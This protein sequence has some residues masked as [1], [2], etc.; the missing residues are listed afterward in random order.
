MLTMR[1]KSRTRGMLYVI[2]L[3]LVSAGLVHLGSTLA[4]PMMAA[5]SGYEPLY[6]ALPVN[7]MTVLPPSTPGNEPLTFHD[8]DQ[9]LAICRY[10]LGAGSLSVDV[11]LPERGW[12][13]GLYTPTGENY[14]VVSSA[15]LQQ[16][17]VTL[18]IDAPKERGFSL[19]SL[20][21]PAPAQ[22]PSRVS[23]PSMTGMVVLRAPSRGRAY[24][25]QL[26]AQLARARC[27]TAPR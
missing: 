5:Q 19:L 17:R 18:T 6:G 7:Q 1:A 20:G 13:V 27:G 21:K 25:A 16:P 11:M 3:S 8:P 4:I 15:G 2:G 24:K 22:D 26:E 9:R 10:D 14:Y 12:S 23:A